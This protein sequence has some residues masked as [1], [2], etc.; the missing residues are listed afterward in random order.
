MTGRAGFVGGLG[1]QANV[2]FRSAKER[3]L[4]EQK[5]TIREI[6]LRSILMDLWFRLI[7]LA[8]VLFAVALIF[9]PKYEFRV[10]IE[11]GAARLTEGR[12]TAAFLQ[13]I[14][15]TCAREDIDQG[16]V[17]GIRRGKN[18]T[19]AFSRT[20]PPHVRQRLRNQWRISG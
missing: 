14:V 12:V 6:T 3:P 2:V 8:I 11:G 18:V 4:A 13:Q 1:N 15:E 9:W 5:A 16:W 20:I 10:R 19:L 7:L 17:A